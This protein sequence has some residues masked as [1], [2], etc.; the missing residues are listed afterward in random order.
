MVKKQK[1]VHLLLPVLSGHPG[2]GGLRCRVPGIPRSPVRLLCQGNAGGARY[3]SRGPG[4]SRTSASHSWSD[5]HP[6]SAHLFELV[7]DIV[8]LTD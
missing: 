8:Y 5:S 3:P 7:V 2:G 1:R 6:G 4:D